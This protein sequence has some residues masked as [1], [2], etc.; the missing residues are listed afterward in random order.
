MITIPAGSFIM[1]SNNGPE[2]ERPAHRVELP[3]FTIDRTPITNARFAAFLNSVG[4]INS[5]GERLFDAD[6]NDARIHRRDERWSA[7]PDFEDH[8]VVEV[9]WSGARD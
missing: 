3:E 2:D 6:D 4:P 8:P 1:G 5:K 7:D 9:S